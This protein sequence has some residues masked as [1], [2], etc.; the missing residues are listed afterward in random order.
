MI[1]SISEVRG[2]GGGG[3]T[4]ELFEKW[5]VLRRICCRVL[6]KNLLFFPL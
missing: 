5:Q 6:F 4:Q 1:A 2:G 3:G